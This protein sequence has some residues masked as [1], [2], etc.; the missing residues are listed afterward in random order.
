MRRVALI[1]AALAVLGS[2]ACSS[3]KKP[4]TWEPGALGSPAPPAVAPAEDGSSG[5]GT[6][7]PAFTQNP[8][9]TVNRSGGPIPSTSSTKISAGGL[10]PYKIGVT[11]QTLQSAKLVSSVAAAKGCDN[12]TTAKGVRKYYSPQLVFFKGRL[13]HLTV[14][15]AT[16][17]TDKG[18]KVGS[19]LANVTGSY[20]SGK[21]LN[22]W[23]GGSA[24]LA[25]SGDYALLF[26]VKN[27]KVA[28]VQAG[29]AEPVQF[30][31]TDNQGC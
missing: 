27:D 5:G 20:P 19:P 2:A 1:L 4:A 6:A 13:L 16:V 15:S 10:G 21:Q 8:D 3:D 26:P 7:K 14:T 29:M 31:Y 22:D 28:L 9:G 11:L 23:A 30:K 25:M 12:Y 18:V 24:W 17:A